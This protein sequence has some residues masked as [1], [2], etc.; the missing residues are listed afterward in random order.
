M[1][2]RIHA[3]LDGELPPEAL[4]PDE[5]ARAARLQ[6]AAE[7]VTRRLQAT[8]APDLS[9]RVMAAL[10]KPAPRAA[11]WRRGAAWLWTPRPVVVA[12]RPAYGLAGAAI[13][14]AISLVTAGALLL[15]A[16]WAWLGYRGSVLSYGRA[17]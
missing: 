14:T 16:S 12:F 8:P 6:A 17:A 10:P 3:Y 7:H 1:T 5:R 9:A 11:A 4:S 2:D 13:A 15:A